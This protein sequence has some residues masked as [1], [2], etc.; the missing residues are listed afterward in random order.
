MDE[1]EIIYQMENKRSVAL[2]NGQEIGECDY[3][4]QDDKWAILHT[5]V[6]PD[7]GGRGIA[8]M[9]VNKL[10]EKAREEGVKLLPICSYA[11]KLMEKEE[12]QDVL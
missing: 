8:K 1:I 6:S 9:L 2:F 5:Y 12:Y 11:K 7:F 10:V 4:W 3:R